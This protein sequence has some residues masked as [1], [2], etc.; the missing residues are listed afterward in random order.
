MLGADARGMEYLLIL[1]QGNKNGNR[2]RTET[3]NFEALRR[4]G[5]SGRG[6]ALEI[7]IGSTSR[8]AA[9]TDVLENRS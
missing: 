4:K 5:G 7:A 8:P 2:D 6:P 1:F 3:K 9:P